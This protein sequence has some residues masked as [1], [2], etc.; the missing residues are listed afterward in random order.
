M[1]KNIKNIG[2]VLIVT[3][4]VVLG[5]FSL[6][7][8][9]VD[10]I[11]FCHFPQGESD[12]GKLFENSPSWHSHEDHDGDFIIEDEYDRERCEALIET[13]ACS[14]GIDNDQDGLTDMDDPGCESETD[15]NETDEGGSNGGGDEANEEDSSSDDDDPVYL[16]GRRR[17]VSS[18]TGGE[19]LGASIDTNTCGIYINSYMK[20]GIDNNPEEV[21]RLQNFL[22][23]QG[24]TMPVTG[25]FGSITDENVKKFQSLYKEEILIPWVQFGFS[26]D[27]SGFVF[28]LTR[29]KINNMVCPGSE[30]YPVLS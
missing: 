21:M 28:K 23:E 18:G 7:N 1:K 14:D 26:D 2:F 17:S 25:Y 24:Y 12:K 6:V 20:M 15:D 5:N 3:L 16:S 22:N 9:T 4:F 27:P 13:Y 30:A 29:Y 8:A 10:K 19:V 11:D